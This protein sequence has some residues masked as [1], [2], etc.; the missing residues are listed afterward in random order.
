[1]LDGLRALID[2]LNSLRHQGYTYVWANLAFVALSLPLI[3]APAALS[4]LFCVGHAARTQPHE[5]DL[6]LFWEVFRANLWRTLPWG[7]LHACFVVVNFTNLITYWNAPGIFQVLRLA[8]MGATVVWF[9]VFL[10]TWPIYYEMRQPSLVGAT[11]NALLMVIQNPFFTI[12]ILIGVVLLAV[13]STVLIASW[14]VLTWGAISSIANAAV[15][16]RLTVFREARI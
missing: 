7:I 1:M 16:N 13:V 2:G 11:R 9:G 4:A 10:Y 8:W 5:A 6:A 12:T 15:L 3:T 14:V